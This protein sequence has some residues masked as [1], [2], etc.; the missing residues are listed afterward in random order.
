MKTK[1]VTALLC[2]VSLLLCLFFSGFA[3][4]AEE[5]PLPD[6]APYLLPLKTTPQKVS[7][8]ITFTCQ[9]GVYRVCG[10][11]DDSTYLSLYGSKTAIPAE[12]SQGTRLNI[13]FASGSV[14]IRLGIRAFSEEKPG[15][16]WLMTTTEN[17]AFTLPDLSAYTGVEVRITVSHADYWLNRFV[18]P[19]IEV[20]GLHRNFLPTNEGVTKHSCGLTFAAEEDTYTL[21]GTATASTYLTIDGSRTTFPLLLET[22]RRLK[23]SLHSGT[24]YVTLGIRAFPKNNSDS[25][26][27]AKTATE[28]EFT[29][30]DLSHYAGAEIRITVTK[31]DIPFDLTLTPAIMGSRPKAYLTIID[32]DGDK[33]F[34]TDVMP[35]MRELKVP[36]ATAVTPTRIG[37]EPRWMT[38]TDILQ[39]QLFGAEVLNHTY[40]HYSGDRLD[41]LSDRDL[42][43]DY[44][45]ARNEMRRRGIKSGEYLVYSS[46]TGDHPRA[47]NFASQ[48]Y[49]CGIRIGGSTI[50]TRHTDPYALSRYRLDYAASE[51]RQDWNPHD[52]QSYVDQ[53]TA[54]GGWQIWM[55]HTSNSIWNQRVL[56]DA[57]GRIVTDEQGT[58]VPMTDAAGNP[59]L[60]GDGT[61]PT[62]GTAVYLPLLRSAIEYARQNGVE[63]VTVQKGYETFY[64]H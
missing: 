21:R 39:C 22:G 6:F 11:P 10:A 45:S 56:T 47:Q 12:F 13:R 62:M 48:L 31:R 3:P 58:P 52:I 17:T 9:N 40:H 44:I 7:H 15:G 27:L 16:E 26:W 19:V 24:A 49:K 46:S 5:P 23:L 35:L 30:P 38:W 53:V 18:C 64:G 8:G 34:K 2:A 51:S 36:I 57:D 55:F 1:S 50:N 37:T 14:H 33:H 28:T 4:A 54:Q 63:I 25:I 42:R 43:Q 41:T 59:V 60:D 29:V 20:E 61:H 32:D